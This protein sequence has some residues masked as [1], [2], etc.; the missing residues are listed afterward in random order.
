VKS[1][2]HFAAVFVFL[3][4]H[5]NISHA[6]FYASGVEPSSVK[7]QQ[8]HSGHFRVIFPAGMQAK[9]LQ[10][11][12]T[13]EY[14]YGAG[15][16]TLRHS[17]AKIPVVLHN[18][19]VV[20]NGF[21]SWAPKR[22]EWYLTPPQD[23]DA[24]GWQQQLAVHEYRHVVQIDKLNRGFTK[25]LGFVIGQQSVGLAAALL[26]RWFLEG[27]AV[28]TE[29]AL[30]NAGRGRSP[31]FEMPLRT[32]ALSGGYHT[33]EKALFGSFRDHVPNHYELGYQMV[34][35]SRKQYGAGLFGNA[36]DLSGRKSY[37][38]F[39]SPF[40][41]SLKNDT[42]YG[43]RNLY[44]VAFDDLT[45]RWKEQEERTGYDSYS[46]INRRTTERYTSYRSP[47][48]LND[49]VIIV[50]RSG[51]ADITRWVAMDRNGN[52]RV[53][54]TP[55]NVNSDRI[56]CAS[57]RVVWTEQ[58]GDVRWT[59]RSYS[60]VKILDVQTGRERVLQRKTRFFAP[61][62]SPDGNTVALVEI[63]LR[64][65]CFI[66]LLDTDSGTETERIAGPPDALLQMPAWSRNGK[67]L[68]M[69][70][71]S[72]RQG[73]SIVKLDMESG[74]YSTVLPATFDDI[75]HPADAGEYALYTGTCNGINNIYA[76][77]Y[78][79]GEVSQVTSSR[80]GAFDPQP[81]ASGSKMIYSEYSAH[82]Y[83]ISEK[84]LDGAFRKPLSEVSDHSVKLYETL[85]G[86]ENF[87]VQDS[88]I[89]QTAHEIKP[90]RKWA[91]LFNIHSWAPLYYRIDA[92][93]V[94]STRLY[95]GL[96]LLS[97]DLLGNMTSSA[98]YS[99]RGYSAFHANFTC[100]G[101]YPV[102]EFTF[103]CG[104]KRDVTGRPEEGPVTVNSQAD[105]IETGVQVYVPLVLTRNRE[106]SGITPY[107]KLAYRNSY[108]YSHQDRHYTKGIAELRYTLS[109]YRYLKMAAI[110]IAPRLGGV[111]RAAYHHAPSGSEQLGSIYYLYGRLYLPGI[112]R[113]HSL[114]LSGAWQRQHTKEY[115]FGSLINFPRGYANGRTEKLG[116]GSLDY[117]LPLL[118]PDW[119]WSHFIYIKRL[120]TNVFCDFARN[121]YR[122]AANGNRILWR[123]DRLFSTGIDLTGDVNFFRINFPVNI[124]IRTTFVP[125]TQK[126][127]PSLLFNVAFN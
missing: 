92:A 112:G 61:T 113:C 81:D 85:A 5:E 77:D 111:I 122:I 13:L 1:F 86:Q 69:I 75:S 47:Q 22:A 119:Q 101:W 88:I 60:V 58:I 82:G 41:K 19:P 23:N 16:K 35:W 93:D 118:Y 117:A 52:E 74:L 2:I 115:L 127:Y 68:L 39:L 72:D 11:A 124:G 98:G 36:V 87:N 96:V 34:A 97:Q 123:N 83:D 42:G 51:M 63:N 67:F 70:V 71:N 106:V 89:P 50:R 43:P 62:L 7:W 91:N 76:V 15:G 18:M 116:I 30:T 14:I 45:R 105:R 65:E 125:E 10:A 25:A 9:G 103:D 6:Q 21:V 4:S 48:Y 3:I 126:V 80:F 114:Q 17:P 107:V 31:A 78:S 56:S 28:A 121:S 20:S 54:F 90:Y 46:A 33:Y 110:D 104:G 49:S 99:W 84:T 108:L 24:Q 55:G 12:N 27:D 109:A 64:N 26:P 40:R 38:F 53:V 120:K 29:T 66:L 79:S 73:K 37:L 59:N 102:I 44:T 57:G 32:I 94:T 8:I 95:P 100:E